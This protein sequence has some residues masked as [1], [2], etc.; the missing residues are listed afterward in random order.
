MPL[1][2]T[3]GSVGVWSTI[4]PPAIP[5]ANAADGGWSVQ[6]YDCEPIDVGFLTHASLTFTGIGECGPATFNYDSGPIW[7]AIN[8]MSCDATSA[9]IYT[10]PM[11]TPNQYDIINTISSAVWSCSSG[12]WIWGSDNALSNPNPNIDP[13][14]TVNSDFCLTVT[15]N[16]GCVH[17]HCELFETLPTDATITGTVADPGILPIGPFCTNDPLVDLEAVD[18]G[19]VWSCQP[20]P[21]T[22]DP[23]QSVSAGIFNPGVGADTYLIQYEI[24]G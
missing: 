21:C 14:P 8:D 23:I 4:Y 19:G 1:T 18:P 16:L 6:I 3:W 22:P 15:D 13:I 24:T 9:S 20:D 11:A 12:P 2:G 7:S 17:Q 5:G 10:I